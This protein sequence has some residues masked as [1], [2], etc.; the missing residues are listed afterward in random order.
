[1]FGPVSCVRIR[2]LN[3]NEPEDEELIWRSLYFCDHLQVLLLHMEKYATELYAQ[4]LECFSTY[5]ILYL[6]VPRPSPPKMHP[7]HH[8]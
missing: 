1:M 7:E 5:I 6:I 4:D 3:W 2:H 8:V